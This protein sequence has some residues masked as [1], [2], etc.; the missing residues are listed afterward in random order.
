[1]RPHEQ[2]QSHK[3]EWLFVLLP[4]SFK[5]M[6]RPNFFPTIGMAFA[7]FKQLHDRV[8]PERNASPLMILV[9]PQSQRQRQRR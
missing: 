8:A 1:V 5:T 2:A 3:T 7:F 9:L 4:E 6:S